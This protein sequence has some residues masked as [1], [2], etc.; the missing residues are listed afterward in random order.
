[1]QG[2][3]VA[4]LKNKLKAVDKEYGRYVKD[5]TDALKKLLPMQ[6]AD[7]AGLFREMKGNPVTIRTLDPP[8]HEFL[9]KREELMVQVAVLEAKGKKKE[10]AKLQGLLRAVAELH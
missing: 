2:S 9:P 4:E 3:A 7:F 10:A 1:M 8:L 5:Y 6:R